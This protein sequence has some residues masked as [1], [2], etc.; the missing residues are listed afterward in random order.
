M[1]AGPAGDC[2]AL[3][4]WAGSRAVFRA[5][6]D[7]RSARPVR[8]ARRERASGRAARS[9]ARTRPRGRRGSERRARDG[10]RPEAPGA[11]DPAATRPLAGSAWCSS[12]AADRDPRAARTVPPAPAA[13]AARSRFPSGRAAPRRRARGSPLP[14]CGPADWH[15]GSGAMDVDRGA[16]V[17]TAW[18]PAECALLANP[19]RDYRHESACDRRPRWKTVP[20]ASARSPGRPDAVVSGASGRDSSPGGS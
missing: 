20:A 13:D 11:S 12:R 4:A 18:A 6:A 19:C 5:R 3:P 8:R 10:T 16:A 9:W 14:S 15:A 2:D 1:A 17:V 7:A